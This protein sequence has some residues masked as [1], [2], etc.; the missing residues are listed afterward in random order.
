MGPAPV[1]EIEQRL[2]RLK[3]EARNGSASPSPD[4]DDLDW[5]LFHSFPGTDVEP[6]QFAALVPVYER[7]L[8]TGATFDVELL[9]VR[10]LELGD[11]IP[12][13][14][15][16]GLARAAARRVIERGFD[17]GDAIAAIRFAARVLPDADGFLD[18]LLDDH[19]C[20]Q[21][22]FQL[23][24]DFIL[25]ERELGDYLALSYLREGDPDAASLLEQFP[26][27][28]RAQERLARLFD[29]QECG[30][31]LR[32]GWWR[33][34]EPAERATLREALQEKLPGF[35]PPDPPTRSTP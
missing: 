9:F 6:A 17:A 21:L 35:A 34:T 13:E 10:S 25:D 33:W 16:M 31:R 32:E 27:S 20:A 3:G 28:K 14:A 18:L 15:R 30:R 4:P 1:E 8:A 24:V 26:L 7:A 5:F 11:A 23:G 12:S 19:D 22:R 29:E 2:A